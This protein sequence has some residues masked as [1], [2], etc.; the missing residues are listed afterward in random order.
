MYD[1]LFQPIKSIISIKETSEKALKRLGIFNVRDLVFY[2][3]YSYNISDTSPNLSSLHD[4][5]LIQAEV[6]IIDILQSRSNRTPTK[7]YVANDTGG[8]TLVFFNRIPPF[9]FSKLKIGGKYT[10][11]GKVQY[12]DGSFQ[13]THPEFIFKKSLS[14]PVEPVYHLTYGLINKQLYDYI[15]TS[16]RSLEVAIGARNSF[17][18]VEQETSNYMSSLINEIKQLHLVGHAPNPSMIVQTIDSTISKLAA[19]E[20]FANQVSLFK[21]KRKEQAVLGRSFNITNEVKNKVLNN[22]GFELTTHQ[23][24]AIKQIE[25]DQA[26]NIQMR[27]LLQGDV[28][29]GKTIVALLTMVNVV[30]C[31]AQVVFMVP[32]DL[33][34][35]QHYQF[36]IK[37]LTRTGINVELLTGKTT[38]KA[39]KAI[40]E[41]LE[42]G[43]INILIGTHAL[44]QEAV[45]FKDLGYVIIDEQ[46]RFGVQQRL[47]LIAK[48]THPDVLVMTATPIPRSLTLTMF[49]DM[50]VSQ[51]K[52]KPKNRLPIVTT[53]TPHNKREQVA[54]SLQKMIDHDQKIYWVCPLIDQND[55]TLEHEDGFT[56]SDVTTRYEELDKIYPGQVA[57]LHGKMKSAGKDA[58]MQKFKD[59][60][61]KILV[62]TTVIEVGIDVPDA[63]LIIVDN[64]EKFGLAQLHQLRGRVGRGELQSYCILIYNSKRFS[65]N[66]R[67]RLEIMRQSN[68]GFYIAEQDLL[69]RGG[70]EILGTKQSGEP[71][72][73]FADLGRDLNIL[74]EANKLAQ[75]SNFSEFTEFQAKLFA[76][77]RQELAKSG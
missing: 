7:I 57:I 22:L 27:R 48:A 65:A 35:L 46:H 38:I 39:R 68:D 59:G 19:K 44:F 50:S 67:N 71:E 2:K 41:N 14:V 13:I 43:T 62:A 54:L 33:L 5:A 20:L 8:L 17:G 49:G 4:N 56:Y 45:T 69:L 29:S 6:S 64:A 23:Q 55:K 63:T 76:K 9:I 37:V 77:D 73:F 21:L 18:K 1:I 30:V 10:V 24:E 40:K 75:N 74:L 51:I 16:I 60:V 3:P 31:G 66:A 28:G 42:N 70:G 52:D 12:F 34:S 32:T 58:V 36:F 15:L 72:F 53:I 47:E 11:H 26:A 25:F 61:I